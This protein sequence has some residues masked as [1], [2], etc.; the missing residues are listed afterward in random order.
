ML[1]AAC[2]VRTQCLGEALQANA[3]GVWGGFTRK[4]RA[5]LSR[6]A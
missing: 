6:R 2:P 3:E 5:A 1:C 4:G